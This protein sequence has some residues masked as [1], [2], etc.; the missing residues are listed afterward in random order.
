MITPPLSAKIAEITKSIDVRLS[1]HK[2]H[3]CLLYQIIH[4]LVKDNLAI[5]SVRERDVLEWFHKITVCGRMEGS[6]CIDFER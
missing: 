2:V 6:S 4:L 3:K 1:R 5:K